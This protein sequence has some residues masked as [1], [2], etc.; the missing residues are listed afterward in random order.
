MTS[1][2]NTAAELHGVTADPA[3]RAGDQHLLTFLDVA[4]VGQ[5]LQGGD[6]GHRDDRGLHERDVRRLAGEPVDAGHRVFSEAAPGEPEHLIP[7]REP[8]HSRA[9][10]LDGARHVQ[11]GHRVPRP[12]QADDRAQ[13]IR[14]ARHHVP[15]APVQARRVHPQHYL[16][17]A[18]LRRGDP[19][20]P[21]HLGG[22]VPVLHDRL[23]RA[24]HRWHAV[25]LAAQSGVLLP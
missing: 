25:L 1:A 6:P 8:G 15:A 5:G 18:S 12:A 7:G 19:R 11:P 2:P 16:A 9:G 14:P 17:A 23:H 13:G 24:A 3:R 20:E 10:H 4:D 21:Q 22:A